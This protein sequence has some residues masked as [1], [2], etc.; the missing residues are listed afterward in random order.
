MKSK[1]TGL[2]LPINV[3]EVFYSAQYEEMVVR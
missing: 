3:G 1:L 2:N